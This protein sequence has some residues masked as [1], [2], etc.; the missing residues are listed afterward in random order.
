MSRCH[1]IVC[2]PARQPQ[3][4]FPN[5]RLTQA[6]RAHVPAGTFKCQKSLTDKPRP[7][8]HLAIPRWRTLRRPMRRSLSLPSSR[9]RNPIPSHTRRLHRRLMQ[10]KRP[11]RLALLAQN[12]PHQPAV[13]IG[14]CS[15]LVADRRD[16]A[17]LYLPRIGHQFY[18]SAV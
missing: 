4:E 14:H 12:A 18:G 8:H 10:P 16:H 11:P 15:A 13:Q 7:Q 2:D 17:R 6:T 9:H 5:R 3:V 1:N